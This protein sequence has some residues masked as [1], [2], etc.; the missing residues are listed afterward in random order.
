MKLKVQ[1]VATFMERFGFIKGLQLYLNIRRNKLSRISLPEIKHPFSLRAGTSDSAIFSQIFLLEEYAM[2]VPFNPEIIVDAGAHIGLFTLYMKNRYPSA[3]FICVEPGK[4]NYEQL[5]QNTKPYE[6]IETI[7]AAIWNQSITLSMT[8]NS[9]FGLSGLQASAS[10]NGD[11]P[12]ITMDL[13]LKKYGISYIDIL[14]IDIETAEKVIF[15]KDSCG[16]LPKVRM[17]VIEL[18]DWLEPG[19]A[20]VF[21]EAVQFYFKD[22]KYSIYGENTV[23]ENLDFGK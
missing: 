15:T 19:C 21:F 20:K 3:R 8:E 1:R 22:Y 14:K 12:G 7:N 2:E 11:T 18:H 9:N 5:K 17:V 6:G 23:I 10:K 13:I 4:D 16:W